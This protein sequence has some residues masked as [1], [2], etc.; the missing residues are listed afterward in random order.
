[1]L[2]VTTLLF[3]LL[4]SAAPAP[5]SHLVIEPC[6]VGDRQ[7]FDSVTCDIAMSNTGDKPIKVSH[8]QAVFPWDS[9][10][11]EVTVP[12]KGTVYLKATLSMR[13]RP[14]FAKHSF[15]LSTDEPGPL[16]QR[17][18]SVHGFVSTVL[19]QTVPTLDF[20]A[21][22]SSAAPVSKDVALSSRE[23][24]DFRIL[25][26]DSKPDYMDVTIGSDGRSVHATL[27]K[28]A[29]WG[30]V[31]EKIKLRINTPRQSH[32]WV[33]VEANVIG[34]VAP[35]G[36]PFAF[37]LMR[38]NAKNEFLLR[39]TSESGKDFK[40][41]SAKLDQVKGKVDVVPCTP[42]AEGCKMLR[43]LVANDQQAGRLQGS[44]LVE[45]PEYHRT[46]P[47]EV[48]GMLLPPDFKVHDLNEEWKDKQASGGAS[49]AAAAPGE[50]NLQQAIKQTTEQVESAPPPGNGPLLRWSV[51][52]DGSV[53]GYI[54]YR[55]DA[56]DG[57]F[58]RVNKDLIAS[59]DTPS[60]A[61]VHY[62][63]RD[64]SAVSGHTYWYE[65]GMVKS[66]GDKVPLSGAQK[67]VAK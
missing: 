24:A 36:N 67:V 21:V 49:Q 11:P 47:I 43:I 3:S 14:G 50:L 29:P 30:L 65:I 17:G 37:G 58:L 39:L 57:P 31:H 41:G 64:D 51:A 12:P 33:D 6:L 46:L 15:R 26:V 61:G 35:N 18:A 45:L 19:D 5:K 48:V 55:A 25:G 52:N 22:K 60:T 38:T 54:I 63:W 56:E 10:E 23:I 44:L 42:A 27:R 4:A 2:P 13:D 7:Q 8:A 1:M 32:A 28:D 34:D 66:N 59:T 20:G 16:A 62:Q 40:I 53:H 9:I